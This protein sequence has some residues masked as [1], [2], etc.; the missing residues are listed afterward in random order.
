MAEIN[1]E[2]EKLSRKT[3]EGYGTSLWSPFCFFFSVDFVHIRTTVGTEVRGKHISKNS[4][5]W[6]W[7]GSRIPVIYHYYVSEHCVQAPEFQK[8]LKSFWG[9]FIIGSVCIQGRCGGEGL[10]LLGFMYAMI[11][12]NHCIHHFVA[13]QSERSKTHNWQNKG[14]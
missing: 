4:S 2:R 13:G 1:T 6:A 12:L 11:D 7:V 8:S 5:I 3:D 9:G 14:L 10:G